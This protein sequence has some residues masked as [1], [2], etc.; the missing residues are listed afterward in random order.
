MK[1]TGIAARKMN[2]DLKK[3]QKK[4]ISG[5]DNFYCKWLCLTADTKSSVLK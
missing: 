5:Q 2:E 4:K 1:R 3:K